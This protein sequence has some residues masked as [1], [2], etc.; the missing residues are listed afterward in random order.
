MTTATV[1]CADIVGSSGVPNV[2]RLLRSAAT[3]YGAVS[4]QR[5]G[6]GLLAVFESVAAG[7]GAALAAER[8]LAGEKRWAPAPVA[9][10]AAL[11]VGDVTWDEE[12]VRGR[13]LAEAA[14]L[15]ST[16]DSGQ[17]LCTDQVRGLA[18][19]GDP[20]LPFGDLDEPRVHEFRWRDARLADHEPL[21]PW[22][23]ERHPPG[24]VGR[25]T[26][27]A[28]LRAELSAAEAGTRTVLVTG[29]RGEGKTGLLSA[30]AREAVRRGF[31][32]LAGR[33]HDP[34]REAYEP[35]AGA[36]R[37]LAGTSAVR[38]LRAGVAEAE[39]C[40]QLARL[41]PA[42]SG[43]PLGMTVPP[44]DDPVSDRYR[45]VRATRTL[46]E[47]LARVR[48]VLLVVDDLHRA[49]AGSL[50]I[51]RSLR[52]DESPPRLLVLVTAR[53]G[54]GV[55]PRGLD[56]R[57]ALRPRRFD[58]AQI[59][60]I[61]AAAPDV[62]LA[63]PEADA[64]RLHHRTGGDALLV[65]E[66][67]RELMAGR[68]LDEVPVADSAARMVADRLDR[69]SPRA[70]AVADLLAVG[71]RMRHETLRAGLGFDGVQFAG[72]VAEM[73]AAGLVT[74]TARWNLQFSHEPTREAVYAALPES[75]AAELHGR[76]A[77]LLL[78]HEA[79]TL[80][81]R[82]YVLA[83]HLLRAARASGEI[84]RVRQAIDAV[85]R[86]AEEALSR[87]AHAEAVTWYEGLLDLLD[88]DPGTSAGR[89]AETLAAC[90]RAMWLAGDSRSWRTLQSA[91]EPARRSGRDDL[92]VAVAS[93]G[94]RGFF[95]TTAVTDPDRIAL[96]EEAL[97]LV[98]PADLRTRA[99]LTAQ[100]AA[101]LT[102][103]YP[104][105]GT[106]PHT[107]RQGD[108]GGTTPHTPRQGDGERR[109]ALSDVALGWARA[110]GDPRILVRVLGL[111]NLTVV[112]EGTPERRRAETEEMLA[113][114]RATG[115]DLALFH[116][117][118][119]GVSGILDTGDT[120]EVTRWLDRAGELAGRLAQPHLFWLV[121]FSRASLLLMR[122]R[123]EEAESEAERALRLG[124]EIGREYEAPAFF[125][126]QTGEIR[127]LRGR[128]GEVRDA[129]HRAV[130]DRMP[131]PA[132]V[133]LRFLT[134][135]D[136]EA[137]GPVLRRIVAEHGVIPPRNLAQRPALDNLAL[138]ASRQGA[139]DLLDPLYKA[140]E[141]HGDTYGHSAVAHHCGHHYLAHLAAASGNPALAAE[142]FEAAAA[143]H[144]RCSVPLLM[145]ES[146]LDWADLDARTPGT[147]LAPP[148]LRERAA[149][150]LTGR[151]A[152]LLERRLSG[153]G[154]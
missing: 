54:Q 114:A 62:R 136:D 107:P 73:T 105:G 138:A 95:S 120:E 112:P 132:H 104:G 9:V 148:G 76:V 19:L 29:E 2:E 87:L 128:L 130:E 52:W 86:A 150:L 121:S 142:H 67:V 48:P 101:E 131:D 45:L 83:G 65:T 134:E 20:D 119:Q 12:G 69:L 61:L 94:D 137:A 124:L 14:R 98:D 49:S 115:D 28:E 42:L 40:R 123:I 30:V 74:Q 8:E 111:R 91:V 151:G 133:L 82:P 21:P 26:E 51:L 7:L 10:R 122:G 129:V 5:R 72:A 149:G 140:L 41:A 139:D 22:L 18:A 15:V 6:G 53:P 39:E 79:R 125:A 102:W 17:V 113:A 23:D 146:L 27:L 153:T 32:V 154:R 60:A 34:A 144:E 96:L 66:V 145:A 152:A 36:V 47:R 70:R 127:R 16:A 100:L 143:V 99:L 63:D 93:T 1:L 44:D 92:I 71:G 108:G 55:R 135:L 64:A 88:L 106:T 3:A 56:R 46:I 77:D 141:P 109:F 57:V 38:L 90:G 37:R 118:F 31:T 43:P 11:S 97:R 33:C 75:R 84:G 58:R 68:D 116:A 110:A 103:A 81:A 25:E 4:L 13:P 117:T 35:I 85:G 78:E 80:G 59:A 24:V 50:E 126:E 89:R 147:A